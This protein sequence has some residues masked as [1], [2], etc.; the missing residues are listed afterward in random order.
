MSNFIIKIN[1]LV[2][3]T[4]QQNNDTIQEKDNNHKIL[5]T[6]KKYDAEAVFINY[7]SR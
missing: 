4:V 1:R 3:S 6:I 7:K 5:S 2:N